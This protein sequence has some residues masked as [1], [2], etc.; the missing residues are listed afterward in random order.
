VA[1]DVVPK[2]KKEVVN[3]NAS[4]ISDLSDVN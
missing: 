2:I 3:V 1:G 4:D